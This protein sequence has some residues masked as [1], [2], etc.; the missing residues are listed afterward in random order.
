MGGG[1]WP[2]FVGG[3]I[4]SDSSENERDLESFNSA[5][6]GSCQELCAIDPL[7]LSLGGV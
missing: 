7:S 4:L 2:L 3:A 6:Y 5:M 1:A